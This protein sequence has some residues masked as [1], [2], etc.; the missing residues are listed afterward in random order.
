MVIAIIGILSL[1]VYLTAYVIVF[2]VENTKMGFSNGIYGFGK[3]CSPV[4]RVWIGDKISDAGYTETVISGFA[5]LNYLWLS[6][7]GAKADR[8]IDIERY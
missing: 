1:V 2:K 5:P 4:L 7:G 3:P 6:F 8:I